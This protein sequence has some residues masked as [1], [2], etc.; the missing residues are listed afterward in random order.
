MHELITCLRFLVG[1]NDQN[2]VTET[3]LPHIKFD[4]MPSAARIKRKRDEDMEN[5]LK[6]MVQSEIEKCNSK[7]LLKLLTVISSC[8][9]R[10]AAQVFQKN[11]GILNF[12]R[13]RKGHF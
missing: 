4:K 1:G 8:V 12:D 11:R 5:N 6:E 13:Y 2:K 10:E 7:Y 3:R 9:Q